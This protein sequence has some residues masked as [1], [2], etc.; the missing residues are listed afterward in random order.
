MEMISH[1]NVRVHPPTEFSARFGC[2]A[3]KRT[4]RSAC[5]IDVVLQIAA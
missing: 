3:G 4:P 1:D 5:G 2:D